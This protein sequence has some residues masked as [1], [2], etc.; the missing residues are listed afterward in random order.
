MHRINLISVRRK[1]FQYASVNIVNK[2]HRNHSLNCLK[3]RIYERFLCLNGASNDFSFANY[4]DI[5][6]IKKNDLKLIFLLEITNKYVRF[7]IYVR[8]ILCH[9]MQN[10]WC[11]ERDFK[12]YKFNSDL[13]LIIK[14]FKNLKYISYASAAA[15]SS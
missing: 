9:L 8:L 3:H 11:Q 13:F 10:Q 5:I 15:S 7:L 4:Y 1:L 12:F 14:L 6:K 2:C